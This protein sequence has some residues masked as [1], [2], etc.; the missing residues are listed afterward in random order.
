MEPR[1]DAFLHQQTAARTADLPLIEPD[2]IDQ[3]LDRAVEVGIVKHDV[4]RL[5]PQFERQRLAAARRG[6]AD[7]AAHLG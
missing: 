7:R 2:R 4:R 3:P 1:R 6:T 5:A